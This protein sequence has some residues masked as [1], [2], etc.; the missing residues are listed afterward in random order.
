VIYSFQIQ[1]SAD[2]PY[3][4]S[5]ERTG[6]NLRAAC[7]CSAGK[8]GTHCKHRINLLNGVVDG[9]VSE[10]LM[11]V[12]AL[13]EL[14]TGS[15]VEAAMAILSN[16]EEKLASVKREVSKAKKQLAASMNH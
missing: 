6:N 16:A 11:E 15:D 10:N 13:K 9:L 3:D 7:T 5:F 14:L 4:V 1:G 2:D 8:N 12:N